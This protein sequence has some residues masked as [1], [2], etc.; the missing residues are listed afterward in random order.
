MWQKWSTAMGNWWLAASSLQHTCS[1]IT[2]HAEFCGETSNQPGDSAPLKP[3]FGAL[4]LLA[5]P[6]TKITFEQEEIS[7]HQQDSGKYD[8]AAGEDW[9][10]YVRVQGAYF[11]GDWSSIVLCTMFLITCIFFNKCL[12]FS[13]DMAGYLLDRP[14]VTYLIQFSQQLY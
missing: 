9:E 8:G 7:D 5:F 1:C 2:S 14:C 11:E 3:S 13:Y 12:Y 6:K 10:N 4:Q